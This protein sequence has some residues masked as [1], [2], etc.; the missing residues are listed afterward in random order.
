MLVLATWTIML[1]A[2]DVTSRRDAL[3]TTTH[4]PTKDRN[5]TTA[6]APSP[7]TSVHSEEKQDAIHET[8]RMKHTKKKLEFVVK[9]VFD[10]AIHFVY[11]AGMEHT[12]H[13]LW[14]QH[15]FPALDKHFNDKHFNGNLV[16]KT[17]I[18]LEAHPP[19]RA[20]RL[21]AIHKEFKKIRR[22]RAM[23]LQT[24]TPPHDSRGK[25]VEARAIDTW[26]TASV[27]GVVSCSYPCQPPHF[28]PDVT[29]TA[30]AAE[31]AGVDLR[32][33]LM[34]RNVS[35]I[36]YDLKRDRV[37]VLARSCRALRDQVAAMDPAFYRCAP[38]HDY[39]A[40]L[41][42]AHS[43]FYGT[44]LATFQSIIG[45]V[46]RPNKTPR[47]PVSAQ[48]AEKYSPVCW[49]RLVACSNQLDRFCDAALARAVFAPPSSLPSRRGRRSRATTPRFRS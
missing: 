42:Y 46:Y 19:E 16:S 36:V 34:T 22:Q 27:V 49:P 24:A 47:T 15:I 11:A 7:H 26:A 13:H 28:N 40:N 4:P 43:D 1:F 44:D 18:E 2:S 8:T 21:A 38:Y 48:V 41:T 30:T 6:S 17:I 33:V 14:H 12:G 35:E 23:K 32:I 39:S 5:K 29:I 20:T 37:C 25:T 10:T 45:A 3:L 31:A 9:R